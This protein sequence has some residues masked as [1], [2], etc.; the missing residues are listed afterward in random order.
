M[1]ELSTGTIF[2]HY[3][4]STGLFTL[5]AYSQPVDDHL[6]KSSNLLKDDSLICSVVFDVSN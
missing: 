5:K 6:G 4:P 1:K 3:T 2:Q